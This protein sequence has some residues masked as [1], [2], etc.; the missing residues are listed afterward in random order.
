[1]PKTIGQFRATN[2]HDRQEAIRR[3]NGRCQMC[4]RTNAKHG[5]TLAVHE[6][7]WGQGPEADASALWAVCLECGDGARAY[8]R[9]LNTRPETLRRISSYKSVH[10]RI[11]ELLRASGVGRPTPSSLISSIAGQRSWKARLR[12]LRRAPFGWR[13]AAVRQKNSSGRWSS[14]YVLLSAGRPARDTEHQNGAQQAA[15]AV[16]PHI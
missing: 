8:L 5:I 6:R 11:G 15:A 2:G 16:R 10:A 14:S 9:S 4:G 3:A 7:L 1:M 12:E 13:I